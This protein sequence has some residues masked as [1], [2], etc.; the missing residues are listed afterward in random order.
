MMARR[1]QR[2]VGLFH[3]VGGE[4]DG[5]AFCA[6][7]LHGIPHG[8][9]ALGIEAGTGLVEEQDLGAVGDGARDLEALGETAAE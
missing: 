1:S 2:G 6:E 3:V 8:D 5:D 7:S 4:D 9:A